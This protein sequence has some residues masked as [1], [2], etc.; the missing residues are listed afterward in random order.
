ML[1]WVIVLLVLANAGF[2]A[3]TQGHL[4]SLGFAPSEQRE[5]ERLQ[6]QMR[7][8]VMRLLNAP[9]P[10]APA[11][12]SAPPVEP[13][14]P[15]PSAPETAPDTRSTETAVPPTACWLVKGFK[16]EQVEALEKQM[17]DL[18]LPKGSWRIEEV[19]SGGRWVV[20]MG[21]YKDELLD[22]KKDE[23][24]ELK[25]EFRT[26]TEAPLGPGLALGTYSSEAAAELGLK[27]VLKKGV[28]SA[29]VEQE[30][31]QA[32][33]HTLRLAEVTAQER[34][35]VEGLDPALMAGKKLQA[36]GE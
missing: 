5:P 2:Y 28:R 33:R 36:C 21:R 24:R 8:E 12:V 7:P 19:N 16:T 9:E 14:N 25:V 1:R 23:L 13:S 10:P 30:R 31:D 35:A 29:R 32:T 20:Y 18:A 4:T 3:W 26:L 15:V 6:A 17:F 22:R 27:D 34:T 11:A